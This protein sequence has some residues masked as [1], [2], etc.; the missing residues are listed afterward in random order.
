MTASPE[1]TTPYPPNFNVSWNQL[2]TGHLGLWRLRGM[3]I[4]IGGAG[5]GGS[6]SYSP[7]ALLSVH[8]QFIGHNCR[9]VVATLKVLVN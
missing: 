3:N 8:A 6:V 4:E 2:R 1:S 7:F 5:G 9:V